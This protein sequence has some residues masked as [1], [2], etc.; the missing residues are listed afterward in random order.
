MSYEIK[1]GLNNI[2]EALGDGKAVSRLV[3]AEQRKATALVELNE[4]LDDILAFGL[5]FLDAKWG[6]S[7]NA[8]DRWG[9]IREALKNRK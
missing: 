2:A 1:V 8:L 9:E 7:Y 6:R 4:K 3:D 5:M